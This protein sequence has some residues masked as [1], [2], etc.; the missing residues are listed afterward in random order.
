[1]QAISVRLHKLQAMFGS[2]PIVV[3]T[4]KDYDREP[5]IFKQLDP[6]E[7]LVLCSQLQIVS[8]EGQTEDCFKMFLRELLKSKLLNKNSI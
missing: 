8:H 6:F 1:M 4:E 3:I 7:V 2:K 5:E